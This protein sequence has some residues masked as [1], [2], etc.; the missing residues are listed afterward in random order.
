MDVKKSSLNP[1]A[2]A[3]IPLSQRGKPNEI[4]SEMSP[5]EDKFAKNKWTTKNLDEETEMDL[6]YLAMTFPGVSEQS[7][8]DVYYANGCDMETS[9]DM[10]KHLELPAEVSQHL[11]DTLDIGDVAEFGF[12]DEVVGVLPKVLSGE[13]S[14]SSS[15]V[16]KYV[17]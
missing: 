12:S 15:G 4:R 16:S 17:Q 1:Y 5:R 11:P 13:A 10:L 8:A 7:L 3:Y 14:G 9:I 2:S 6:A